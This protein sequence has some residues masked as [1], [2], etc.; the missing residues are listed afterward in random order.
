MPVVPIVFKTGWWLRFP[1]HPTITDKAITQHDRG[2][3]IRFSFVNDDEKV[4]WDLSRIQL[5]QLIND[6]EVRQ[7][8]VDKNLSTIL[9]YRHDIELWKF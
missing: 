5:L 3:A 9:E 1:L 7:Y 8:V 2:V 6:R 4:E